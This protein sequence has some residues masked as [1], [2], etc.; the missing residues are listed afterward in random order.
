MEIIQEGSRTHYRLE[1]MSSPV[2]HELLFDARHHTEFFHYKGRKHGDLHS[3]VEDADTSDL[4][5]LKIFFDA[6][7]NERTEDIP[8]MRTQRNIWT[9]LGL[10]AGL[11]S[12]LSMAVSGVLAFT[13]I[14]F[15]QRHET[16]VGVSVF[17]PI[18]PAFFSLAAATTYADNLNR[19]EARRLLE[20]RLAH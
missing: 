15:L 2:V 4:A 12:I 19:A 11:Y 5:D 6:Y 1:G 3:L 13:H 8:Y 16:L 18:V 10:G 9:A 7:V 20:E 14:E 17:A